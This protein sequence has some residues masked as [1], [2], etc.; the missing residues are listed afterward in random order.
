MKTKSPTKSR[1]EACAL[2]LFVQK[3][4]HATT[5]KDIAQAI[6]LT[7][8]ALYRHFKSKD[9]LA[10]ILFLEGYA[11]CANDVLKFISQGAT[12]E[13]RVKAVVYYFC[14]QFDT[15]PELFQYLLLSQYSYN[16]DSK[17]RTIYLAL[18]TLFEEAIESKKIPTPDPAFCVSIMS[19]IIFQAAI[20]RIHNKINR[21]M[22][23]DKAHLF[24]AI[25]AA[26]HIKIL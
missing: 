12:F 11:V 14:Q 16:F 7:E 18:L 24:Q 10:E 23:E 8:G 17:R 15:N 13:E 2:A 5:I 25:L 26:L 19:G 6:G 4:V 9:E 3:G 21:T 20:D 22:S 1:I